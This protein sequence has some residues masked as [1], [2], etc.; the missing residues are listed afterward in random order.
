M[1]RWAESNTGGGKRKVVVPP[2]RH[3]GLGIAA[4]LCEVVKHGFEALVSVGALSREISSGE[5]ERVG[6][7]VDR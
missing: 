7:E 5:R 3:V 6:W 2:E 4:K 1:R